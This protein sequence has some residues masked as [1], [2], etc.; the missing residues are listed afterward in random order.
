MANWG[1]FNELRDQ[2]ERRKARLTR[3]A[4]PPVQSLFFCLAEELERSESSLELDAI[5]T[6]LSPVLD[7]DHWNEGRLPLFLRPRQRGNTLENAE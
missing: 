4:P 5:G 6:E 7:G 2:D 1:N 3:A